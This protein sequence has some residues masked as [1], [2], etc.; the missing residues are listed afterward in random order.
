MKIQQIPRDDG[1]SFFDL[2]WSLI[3]TSVLYRVNSSYRYMYVL[4]LPPWN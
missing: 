3:T 1:N 2:T 4:M